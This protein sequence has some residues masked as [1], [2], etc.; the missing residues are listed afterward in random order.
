MNIIDSLIAKKIVGGGG[1]GGSVPEYTGSYTVTP[2]E[3]TQTLSTDGKKCTDDIT[4]N[5]IPSTYIGSGVTQKAAATYTPTTSDQTIAA[6]QYLSG[7]QTVKGD[8]NLVAGNIKKDVQLFGVTGSY[9]GGGITPSGT[10]PITQNGQV[11]V[12]QYATADVAVPVSSGG[13]REYIF[14]DL[15]QIISQTARTDKYNVDF[16]SNGQFYDSIEIQYYVSNVPKGR[17]YYCAGNAKTLVYSTSTAHG[18][19]E[20]DTSYRKIKISGGD[21]ANNATLLSFLTRIDDWQEPASF[22][23]DSMY[24]YLDIPID[25]YSV[26]IYLDHPAG[27]YGG[28]YYGDGVGTSLNQHPNGSVSHTFE[29]SGKYVV[30]IYAD[31]GL[32]KASTSRT[33]NILGGN[34]MSQ[35]LRRL[36]LTTS[37]AYIINDATYPSDGLFAGCYSLVSVDNLC[38]YSYYSFRYSSIENAEIVKRTGFD[39]IG[40]SAFEYCRYLKNIKIPAGITTI[41]SKAFK[42]C[43]RAEKFRFED[44]TPP[45][46]ANSDAFIGIPTTCEFYVPSSALAAYLTA[47]NYPSPSTYTYIGFGT[48]ADGTTLK[49][50]DMTASYALTWYATKEDAIAQTNP[51]TVGNGN[52]IYCRYT[53][54]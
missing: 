35:S 32:Y 5:P 36:R 28:V 40:E 29:F 51:I 27:Y 18:W 1:G 6:N 45:T 7:A 19:G 14:D 38:I 4:V 17:I 3:Q 23:G 10:I 26:S 53:A 48:F 2:T 42:D 8:A 52:E 15:P 41:E 31:N 54:V 21:D 22:D 34:T 13:V 16:E 49:T 33:S 30:Q 25:G 20:I 39:N 43:Q 12:S 9:E 46:V 11:D 24:L 47:T 37:G 44:A 50:E